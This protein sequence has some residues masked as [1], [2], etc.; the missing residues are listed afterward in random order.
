MFLAV[1][2]LKKGFRM[3]EI[4]ELIKTHR[5]LEERGLNLISVSDTPILHNEHGECYLA[6]FNSIGGGTI[7][8]LYT[9]ND[10]LW[11]HGPIIQKVLRDSK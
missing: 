3:D 8:G 1:N 7:T 9:A 2:Y 4:I 10:D 11:F 5:K 6:S